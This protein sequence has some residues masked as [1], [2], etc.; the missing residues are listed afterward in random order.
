MKFPCGPLLVLLTAIHAGAQVSA[1]T[2]GFENLHPPDPDQ[3]EL[4]ITH[5][6]MGTEFVF[7]VYG[8]QERMDQPQLARAC[9]KAFAAIDA[10]EQRIS[11]WIPGSECS[12]VNDRAAVEPV[13]VGEDMVRLLRYSWRTYEETGGAFDVT[14]GPLIKLWG[15]Y[16]KEG[17]FPADTELRDALAVVGMNKVHLDGFTDR[18][19]FDKPGMSID[20][21]GIGKGD[22]VDLAAKILVEN[23][24]ERG[25]LHSGTSSV[26]TIGS[27]PGGGGWPVKISNPLDRTQEALDEVQLRGESLSTAGADGRFFEMNGRRYGHIFDPT[28]G[29]PVESPLSVSVIAPTGI[30][31]DALDTAFVVMGLDKIK[32]YCGQHPQVRAIVVLEEEGV[33][34]TVRVNFPP[35][36]GVQSPPKV[37]AVLSGS[38]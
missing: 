31:T 27:P 29:I 20:F 21:G 9:E 7:R 17:H 36:E 2:E 5:P 25:I 19:T 1:T 22:A 38:T 37:P 23:G 4:E 35:E 24:I 26:V 3:V 14:V 13:P 32:A 28:T 6:A 16:R 34:K 30:E 12:Q 33:L 15:F 18:V 8:S 10:L 11:N